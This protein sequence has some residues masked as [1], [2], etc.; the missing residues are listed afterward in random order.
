MKSLLKYI[1]DKKVY[2]LITFITFIIGWFLV[3]KGMSL[4]VERSKLSNIFVS[5][6]T[7]LIATA[8]V[9]ILD[10]WKNYSIANIFKKIDNIINEAGLEQV[11]RKRDIDRYDDLVQNFKNSIDICGYSLGGFFE[12]FSDTVSAK[13]V[14]NPSIIVRVIFVDPK[15][16][17]AKIRAAIEGKS[18]DLYKN[19]FETFKNFFTN[20]SNVEIRTIDVPLSSMIFRIDS[21]LFMGPHFYKKQSKAT[22]TFE[23][24]EGNWL[25]KE[26]Q[27][28][29]NRMW[30]NAQ[31]I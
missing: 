30:D 9:L 25:F 16:D 14:Q 18:P 21:I 1:S 26:Y 8:I 13:I 19:K 23:L 28:E 15:S 12:S 2:G 17:A 24:R 11:Y 29:F 27:D 10:I 3:D 7:S 5:I 6:G 31:P 4:P 22:H 20:N